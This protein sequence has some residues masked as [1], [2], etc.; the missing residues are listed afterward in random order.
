MV[1]ELSNETQISSIIHT[2]RLSPALADWKSIINVNLFA[3]RDLLDTLEEMKVVRSGITTVLIASMAGATAEKNA[4]VDKILEL[5]NNDDLLRQLLPHLERIAGSNHPNEITG[6]AYGLSKRENIRACEERAPAWGEFGSRI[7]SISPSL[8]FTP[9]GRKE[10]E[11]N[12]QAASVFEAT[13]L[14]RWG[15]PIDIANVVR[16]LCSED[17]SFI[18]GCDLRVDGG[19][20]P[21]L[22]GASF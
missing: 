9:M 8:I 2:A 11:T 1:K 10:V 16:F 7:L 3:T 15:S 4:D 18:T 12:P 20:T 22:L 21:A 17:A 14:K 13:P 19:V 5:E 6:P